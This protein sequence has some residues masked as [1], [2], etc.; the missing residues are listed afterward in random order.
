LL[1]SLVIFDINRAAAIIAIGL[2][3]IVDRG[4]KIFIP[5]ANLEISTVRNLPMR[6]LEV[7]ISAGA[8]LIAYLIIQ[9]V[10]WLNDE[11]T[12]SLETEWNRMC[13]IAGWA[14][15]VVRDLDP[16][17]NRR[18]QAILQRCS[19][20][21]DANLSIQIWHHEQN[22]WSIITHAILHP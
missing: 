22:S 14:F 8:V 4:S 5:A 18:V 16:Y 20:G 2:M 7:L 6:N 3:L 1:I 17:A 9:A 15:A 11:G 13:R 10:W 12:I 19:R 21:Q